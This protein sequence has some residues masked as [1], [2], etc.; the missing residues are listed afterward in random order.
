MESRYLS[1]LKIDQETPNQSTNSIL[2]SLLW[3]TYVVNIQQKDQD[4]KM[5]ENDKD[6]EVKNFDSIEG[7]VSTNEILYKA[8]RSQGKFKSNHESI[9]HLYHDIQL[10]LNSLC[11]RHQFHERWNKR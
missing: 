8:N 9:V 5:G 11:L 4:R 2:E 3:V 6:Q 1:K 7:S 10:Y